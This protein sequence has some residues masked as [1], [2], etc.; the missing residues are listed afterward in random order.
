MR[1]AISAIIIQNRDYLLVR[2]KDNY[3]FPGGKPEPG[4]SDE[5]CLRR[6]VRE[7][8]SGTNLKNIRAYKSFDGKSPNKGDLIQIVCYLADLDGPLG[9]PSAEIT[10]VK[11]CDRQDSFEVSEPTRKA[12][13]S[14]R[15]DDL[16]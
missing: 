10:E 15:L 12:L 8:L 9:N 14:L 4:E 1:K 16:I 7:E 5:E 2:K 6:E 13:D 3:I 11:W